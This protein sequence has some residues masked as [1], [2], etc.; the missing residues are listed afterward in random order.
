MATIR[1][2]LA[3]A[4]VIIGAGLAGL[5]DGAAAGAAARASCSPRRRS[6][7]GAAIAWAQGGVAA[8]VGRRRRPGAARRRHAGRRR[9]ARRSRRRSSRIAAAAP[10]AIAELVSA[11]RALRPRR[12]TARFALGLRGGA[13]PPPHRPCARRR[14]RRRDRARAGRRGARHAL[15]H[16]RRGPEARRLLV[17]D[18]GVVRRAGGAPDG[19]PACCATA[20]RRARHRRHGR[21]LSPTPPIRSAPPARAWRWPRAPARRSADLEFVQFHPTALAVGLDPMPLVTEALRGEGAVLVDETGARFMAGR[22]RAE[23]APRDVVAR[24]VAR[25]HRRRPPRL[26]RCAPGA[27]RRLPRALPRHRRALPR[28]PASIPRDQP[29]PVRPAAHYH[30]GGIAVDAGAAAPSPACGP[31]ARSRRPAC[32]APTGWPATRC[33]RPWCSA[34]CRGRQHRRRVVRQPLPAHAAGGRCRPPPDRG[35]PLRAPGRARRS[36]WCATRRPASAAVARLQPLAFRGGA[37]G[38]S[39]PGGAADRHGGARPRGKPRRPLPRRL[40][41]CRR[42]PGRAA[43]CSASTTPARADLPRRAAAHRLATASSAEP[44][45]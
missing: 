7:Q 1:S 26:P 44:D 27:G 6:A 33:S 30:M 35:G 43:W 37:R 45:P 40:P 13:Q 36:A 12:R 19:A 42:P 22:G 34:G 25:A 16:R 14:H 20:S 5:I 23:L 17:D 32:T 28:P 2:E 15:D 29:I 18:G 10:A 41:A 24:A 39:R 9:R 38:R 21:A 3:G 4:P 8:A 11:R 31:A